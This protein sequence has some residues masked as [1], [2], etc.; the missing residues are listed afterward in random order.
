MNPM[1]MYE[2][3]FVYK[4]VR[5]DLNNIIYERYSSKVAKSFLA[6]SKL[7]VIDLLQHIISMLIASVFYT[8][9]QYKKYNYAFSVRSLN[10]AR[11]SNL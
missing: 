8:I 1:R 10:W 2:K 9:T 7:P 5:Y 6:T 11:I 3:M 4:L